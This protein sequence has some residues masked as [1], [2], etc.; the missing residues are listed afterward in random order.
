MKHCY[1]GMA[2]LGQGA[3]LFMK[4]F[5]G[6]FIGKRTCREDFDGYIAGKAVIMRQVHP[7]HA[8]LAQFLDDAIASQRFAQHRELVFQPTP[9]IGRPE[10]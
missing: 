7:S 8:A 2:Q 6:G 10:P 5:A 1:V 3:R 9:A 4:S